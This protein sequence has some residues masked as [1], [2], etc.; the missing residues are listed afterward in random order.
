M[1]KAKISTADRPLFLMSFLSLHVNSHVLKL[2]VLARCLSYGHPMRWLQ[3]SYHEDFTLDK[4]DAG[5]TFLGSWTHQ[6]L[7]GI[8][9]VAITKH[10]AIRLRKDMPQSNVPK[11]SWLHLKSKVSFSTC[12]IIL[13]EACSWGGRFFSNAQQ[14]GSHFEVGALAGG[15]ELTR[16]RAERSQAF[17]VCSPC[18]SKRPRR[19]SSRNAE[20]SSLLDSSGIFASQ[21]CQRIGGV[22]VTKRRTVVTCGLALRLRVSKV[23]TVSRIRG[24]A[25]AKCRTVVTFGLAF[26]EERRERKKRGERRA[27]REERRGGERRREE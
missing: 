10:T 20:L 12:G 3:A 11:Y 25:V 22:L 8:K 21:K 17:A 19:K 14:K 4:H 13:V 26:G 5:A 1:M 16:I 24:V 27:E 6:R 2:R 7:R 23:S 18:V 15:W 9:A